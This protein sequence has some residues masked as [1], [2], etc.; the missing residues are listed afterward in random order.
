MG[1]LEFAAQTLVFGF[2]EGG[3]GVGQRRVLALGLP[4]DQLG[5]AG[6]TEVLV[7]VTRFASITPVRIR[8]MPVSSTR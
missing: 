5:D 1:G 7:S 8:W 4:L 3:V 6:Q 2:V